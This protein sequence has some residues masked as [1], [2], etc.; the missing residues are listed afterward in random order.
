MLIEPGIGPAETQTKT[1]WPGGKAFAFTIFD[2]TDL[3]SL[4]NI[5]NVYAFLADCGFRT[6][7]SVWPVRGM[8]EPKLGGLT[9]DDPAYLDWLKELQSLGF[10]IGFHNT[11][12]HS[13]LRHET[14]Q[15]IER[16]ADLF[17]DFPKTMANHAH[18]EEGIYWGN[19]RVTGLQQ[20]CYNL[21]TRNRKGRFRGHI[22]GDPFFWGD[23]CREKIKYVRNFVYRDIN[24]LKKCPYMPYHDRRRPF[25]QYWFASSEGPT[26][27]PFNECI[28]EENQDRLQEEGGACI[29]YTHLA[30]GFSRGDGL[31]GLFRNLMTRLSKKNGWF[32]PVGTL[33]DHLLERNGHREITDT[34]RGKLERSWLLDKIW[35][36][37]S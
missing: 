36:G 13:S 20:L 11:T 7:K 32:V 4:E 9:C 25:V 27:G 30:C 33:L 19:H 35:S 29:M 34:Q 3:V 12:F 15:G 2:D 31:D 8:R 17:G 26:V 14:I 24:T 16:F 10:E 28:S 6:T 5:R 18:C 37:T 21:F 23:V 1:I 22:E